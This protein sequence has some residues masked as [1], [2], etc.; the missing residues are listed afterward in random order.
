M[1]EFTPLKQ[2]DYAAVKQL[3]QE[4]FDLNEDK[5][6]SPAWKERR[7][8]ASLGYWRGSALLAAA[9]VRGNCLE[10]IF[11]S[12]V[13]RGSGVGTQLLQTLLAISPALHLTPV[14]DL[15]VIRWYESQGFRLSSQK[16]IRK[17]MVHTPYE[18]RSRSQ[19][20]TVRPIE[21]NLQIIVTA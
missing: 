4:A 7:E 17:V 8:D 19:N 21:S 13:C 3:F 16:G 14:N 1:C 6:L 11:V 15:R 5:Y 2:T 10:Y 9:V 18:L 12:D 20:A